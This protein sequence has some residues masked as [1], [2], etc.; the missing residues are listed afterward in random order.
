M[1]IDEQSTKQKIKQTLNALFNLKADLT[2]IK[3]ILAQNNVFTKHF[4][5]KM[6]IFK[7]VVT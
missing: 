2:F 4:V 3:N 1:T 5:N 6:R 7:F